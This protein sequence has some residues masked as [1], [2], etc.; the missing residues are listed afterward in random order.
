[1]ANLS[2]DDVLKLARLARLSLTDEEIDE[3]GR[4]LNEI[5]QY[6]EQLQSIDIAGLEPTSQVT[7]LT[8]VTRED[9][10]RS[11]GYD[12]KDLLKNVPQV[13]DDHIKVRRMIG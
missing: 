5:L 7:G 4:E 9:E 6:V 13:Q 2:R 1:M 11:Y 12:P 3:Y 10:V 8:N